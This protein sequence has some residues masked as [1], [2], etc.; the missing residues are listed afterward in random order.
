M[1]SRSDDC[2]VPASGKTLGGRGEGQQD[3]PC[4]TE[5]DLESELP[6]VPDWARKPPAPPQ[7]NLFEDERDR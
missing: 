5:S 1:D 7:P 6:P 3:P 2:G 4:F